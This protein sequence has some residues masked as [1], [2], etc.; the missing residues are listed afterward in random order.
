MQQFTA[1]VVTSSD[2]RYSKRSVVWHSSKMP[3]RLSDLLS[4][5]RTTRRM[6]IRKFFVK[7]QPSKVTLYSENSEANSFHCND[8][9]DLQSATQYGVRVADL[10][11]SRDYAPVQGTVCEVVTSSGESSNSSVTAT[12]LQDNEETL[13]NTV[14]PKKPHESTIPVQIIETQ[15]Q[16]KK[17]RIL[18]FQGR[19]FQD[20]PW[21]HY[22]D[23]V[24]GVLCFHCAKAKSLK[25]TE[26]YKNAEEAFC[27][28]GYTN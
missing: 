17:K 12:S 19:W 6:D 25:L 14:A 16:T 26:L 20:F 15:T 21:L 23:R 28:T 22:S 13:E 5:G 9:P 18:H 7:K 4:S 1:L 8:M 3:K 2:P 11:L 10:E 27:S 24:A